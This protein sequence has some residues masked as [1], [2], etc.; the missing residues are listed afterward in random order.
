M[1]FMFYKLVNTIFFC[2]KHKNSCYTYSM[3]L[4]GAGRW[5]LRGI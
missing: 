5:T 4:R 1:Q 2:M 3:T